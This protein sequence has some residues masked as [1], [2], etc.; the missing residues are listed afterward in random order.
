MTTTYPQAEDRL[1]RFLAR[2]HSEVGETGRTILLTHGTRTKNVAVLLHGMSASPTQF[3]ELA[4]ALYER[5]YN[6]LVPRLP[7][8]GYSDRMTDALSALSAGDLK[9][10]TTEAIEIAF[11]L[12][13]SVTVIGFSLGGLLAAWTAQF[14]RVAT[15]MCISPFLG[16]A[17]VPHRFAKLTSFLMLRLPNQFHWWNPL[18]R[19]KQLPAH[20]Y[21]RYATHGVGQ[22]YRLVHDVFADA[23]AH[24]P[25]AA[26]IIVVTNSREMTINNRS[27]KKLVQH[28]RDSAPEAVSTYE[29]KDLPISHDIIEPQRARNV[30]I[31]ERVYPKLL[32]LLGE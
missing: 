4:R 9:N 23:Q 26:K 22:A 7:R 17:G 30:D 13:E 12:G 29:F 20:G 6:V 11:G 2:D 27:A 28:W 25:R 16:V 15:V 32:E 5:G 14:H 19:E 8:H 3:V 31:I 21:P 10:V 1:R 18:K 24:A